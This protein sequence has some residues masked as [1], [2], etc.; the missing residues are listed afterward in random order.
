MPRQARLD[1]PGTLHH[2]IIRGLER[3][4]IVRDDEDRQAFVTRLAALV[5]ATR[6]LVYA[7]ALLPNHAHLLL[8]TGPVGLPTVMRRLLTGYAIAFN[9][10]HRRVGHLFQNRYKSIV[11]EDDPYFRELVR[12]IHLN[13]LRAGLVPAL[14]RLECYP[15]A[16]HAGL[17][18]TVPQP[19]LAVAAV[20]PWFGSTPTQARRAYRRYVAE[21]VPLGRRPE[22]VGGGLIRSA[23][24]WAVV[25]AWRRRGEANAADPRILGTGDFVERLVAE[26]EA[27]QRPQPDVRHRPQAA[28]RLIRTVCSQAGIGEAELRTGSRRRPVVQRRVE[29]ART[30]V[31]T[32]GFSLAEVARE[33][34][35]S[36][37]A[38]CRALRR[39]GD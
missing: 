2:V 32:L 30:L 13:P 4:L 3:G 33:L 36:T 11:C 17:L 16:G 39:A 21:G 26:A 22:L 12:Y 31:R 37:S 28:A 38:I 24:G 6:T 18:G 23:G 10:R 14:R 5:Q 7:W 19:W 1:A 29:V 34:G 20:L 8:R 35:V 9:R 15:W 25:Q 27:Q